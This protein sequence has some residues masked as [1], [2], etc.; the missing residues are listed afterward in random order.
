MPASK[1][2]A[3]PN[4]SSTYFQIT[5][6]KSSQILKLLLICFKIIS[7]LF[8]VIQTHIEEPDVTPPAVQFPLEELIFSTDDIEKAID[9][10]QNSSSCPQIEILFSVL[11]PCKKNPQLS[12]ETNLGSVL[13]N[14]SNSKALQ[15][16][17]NYMGSAKEKVALTTAGPL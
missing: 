10:I 12:H 3:K 9:S 6:N 5:R 14:W 7:D 13:L 17:I 4:Q 15:S 11:K 1:G 8:S 2:I 16:A